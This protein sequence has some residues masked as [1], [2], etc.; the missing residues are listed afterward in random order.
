MPVIDA[1]TKTDRFMRIQILLRRKRE[2]IRTSEV[3]D[4]LQVSERTARRYMFELIASGRLPARKEGWVWKLVEGARFDLLPVRLDL[5]EALALY[6][7][8]RLLSAHSDKHNP[9]VVSA[10]NKLASALPQPMGEHILSTAAGAARRREYPVYLNVLETLTHAWAERRQVRL[11]YA[12]PRTEEMTERVFDP[13]FIE[14]SAIGYACYVIGFDHL[15][16]EIREFK[17]ER[18]ARAD[19]LDTSYEIQEGFD[20]YAYLANAWGVMGGKE[21]TEVRLRFSREVTYRIRESDWPGV[22]GME[23]TPDGGCVMSLRV[24]HTLEMVPWIR[25]WG[26]DCEVLEPEA[27]RRQIAE[28]MKKAAEVYGR[29]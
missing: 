1:L 23:D 24:S 25:G 29:G 9:H 19:L 8:A 14:P 4:I 28:D 7:A 27:L 16:G 5:H 12:N 21:V 20:P 6:L 22:T 11:I 13:Y 10:M 15:R 18:V 17:V 2:G 3:A 26:P